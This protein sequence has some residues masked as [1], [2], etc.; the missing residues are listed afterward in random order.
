MFSFTNIG[1]LL[2]TTYAAYTFLVSWSKQTTARR[3]GCKPGAKVTSWDPFL[4][5]DL[6]IKLRLADFAG[7]RS[8]TYKALHQQYGQTFLMKALNT[9]IQTCQPENIKAICTTAFDDW[10]VGPMRG[11]IG[12]PFIDHG[13]FTDDGE[14][15][16]HARSLIR[17]TFAKAEIA[18]LA[19]FETRTNRYLS[20][21]PRDGRTF[22]ILPLTKRLVSRAIL[23]ETNAY[24]TGL[25]RSALSNSYWIQQLNL[26]LVN[27]QTVSMKRHRSKLTSL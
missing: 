4:G 13:I 3:H 5:L 17:P 21:I 15:W 27:R 8:Q 9:D 2:V 11:N 23:K 20:L 7:R 6:F 14:F 16:K 24:M 10:G 12:L 1:V 22:D 25:M 19:S 18:D 26:S